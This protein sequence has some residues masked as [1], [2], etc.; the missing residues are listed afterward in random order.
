M[1]YLLLLLISLLPL[2]AWAQAPVLQWE[3][4]F[5]NRLRPEYAVGIDYSQPNRILITGGT[6]IPSSPG[7]GCCSGEQSTVW[8]FN[9]RG[10]SIRT[11]F[12]IIGTTNESAAATATTVLSNGD[13][14]LIGYGYDATQTTFLTR[15]ASDFLFVAKTDS[16]GTIRWVRR[17]NQGQSFGTT[18][19]PLPLPDGGALLLLS[20]SVGTTIFNLI[21]YTYVA[22]VDS[23]GNMLWQRRYGADFSSLSHAVACPDGSYA[24]AGY[25]TRRNLQNRPVSNAWLLRLTADGD[26]LSN[27][28]WGNL[29]DNLAI[30]DLQITSDNGLLLAGIHTPN[31]YATPATPS[32]GWLEKLDSAGHTQWS[33]ELSASNPVGGAGAGLRWLRVLQNGDFL[34]HG[35]RY[36]SPAPSSTIGYLARWRMPTVGSTTP[37]PV[38]ELQLSGDYSVPYQAAM[39]P[40]GSLTLG[41][42]WDAPVPAPAPPNTRYSH[43]RLQH[44]ASQ[45][46]PYAADL[47]QTPPQAN[48]AFVVPPAAPDSLNLFD[49]SDPGPQYGQLVRWRWVL[50]DGTVVERGQPGWVRHKY[51][52][53]PPAG[54]PVTLTVTNNLGCTSTQ[55]LYP[56][57]LPS[58]SQQARELAGRAVLYPNPACGAVTLMLS[59]APGGAVTVAAV[60]ALGQVVLTRAGMAVGGSLTLGLEVSQLAAGVYAVRVTTSQGSFVKRLVR[61]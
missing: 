59:G 58:A 41:N 45:G 39:A 56:F 28:Y 19:P 48:A 38:W 14:L 1:K 25:Q 46:L 32:L 13:L 49:I 36:Q 21:N 31:L 47:C 29:F 35:V 9:H 52:V 15:R 23:L 17:Y 2:A 27:R 8:T 42:S 34:L 10:D 20:Q 7:Q 18:V 40:D 30:N 22:R 57:G 54:T 44:Y 53:L 4:R 50:G 11:V 51:A 43:I 26:T 16:L 37:T 6:S 3:R 24:L 12:P 60:N 55:T 5:G 33:Y 61:Q